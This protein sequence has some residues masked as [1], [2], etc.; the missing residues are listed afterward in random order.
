MAADRVHLALGHRVH[1][2]LDPPLRS[3]G[4]HLAAPKYRPTKTREE[5]DQQRPGPVEPGAPAVSRE[6]PPSKDR[7]HYGRTVDQAEFTPL[8]KNRGQ[9]WINSYDREVRV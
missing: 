2:R 8:V 1:H 5:D 7:D 4:C 6:G 9:L 3:P